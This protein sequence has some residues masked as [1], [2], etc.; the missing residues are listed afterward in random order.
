[1]VGGQK[2]KSCG[3]FSNETESLARKVAPDR[4]HEESPQ[5][6]VPEIHHQLPLVAILLTILN[7]PIE[8]S[9]S[10]VTK[11]ASAKIHIEENR[12]RW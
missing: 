12:R 6:L 5:K 8:G 4:E 1:M 2:E 7:L 10:N 9:I 3:Q 11:I